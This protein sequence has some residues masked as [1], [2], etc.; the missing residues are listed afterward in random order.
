MSWACNIET[1]QNDG[2]PLLHCLASVVW[3]VDKSHSSS[4]AGKAAGEDLCSLDQW[5]LQGLLLS[6]EVAGSVRVGCGDAEESL[7]LKL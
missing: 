1:G 5:N 2:T 6:K 7:L 4:F 3:Q